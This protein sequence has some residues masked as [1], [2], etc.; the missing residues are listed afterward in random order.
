MGFMGLFLGFAGGIF[1]L[2]QFAVLREYANMILGFC[3]VAGGLVLL[4]VGDWLF[5]PMERS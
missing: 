3:I 4:W 5:E 1:L 2:S